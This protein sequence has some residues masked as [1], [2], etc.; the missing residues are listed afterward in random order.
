MDDTILSLTAQ[1]VSVFVSHNS[2]PTDQLPSLIGSVHRTLST[3]GQ[4]PVEATKTEP[5]VEVKK[6]VFGDHLVCLACGKHFRTIKRHLG[7]EHR[8]TP[9]Q[10]RERFGLSHSYPMVAPNYAQMRSTMAKKLGLG[11]GGHR[12]AP[13][14]AGRKRG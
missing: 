3:V 14:K 2:M 12:K 1:I 9:E 4:A 5:V 8:M 11:L 10:Y 13:K 7:S 6:S